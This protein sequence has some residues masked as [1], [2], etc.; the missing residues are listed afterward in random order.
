MRM[1]SGVVG[2][3]P[4]RCAGAYGV[5][6]RGNLPEGVTQGCSPASHGQCLG[7]EPKGEGRGSSQDQN[8]SNP[9]AI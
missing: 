7:G 6:A 4:A 3:G 5:N 2:I 8:C 9:Y 1:E